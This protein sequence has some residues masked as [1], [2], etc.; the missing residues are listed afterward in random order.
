MLTGPMFGIKMRGASREALE[1][2]ETVLQEAGLGLDAFASF[3]KVMPGARRVAQLLPRDLKI[4]PDS[5]GI[6]VHFE[7]P[8]GAYAT[9]VIRSFLG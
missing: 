8:P 4:C 3:R 1:R 9:E 7:L 6:R 5:K 2:E